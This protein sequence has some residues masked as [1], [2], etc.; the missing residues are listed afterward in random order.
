MLMQ[1]LY[2]S[3]SQPVAKDNLIYLSFGQGSAAKD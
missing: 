3:P 2:V 1:D